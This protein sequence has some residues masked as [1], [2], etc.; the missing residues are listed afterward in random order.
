MIVFSPQVSSI[1]TAVLLT[2][3]H[4][5]IAMPKGE[6]IGPN[7]F[8]SLPILDADSYSL[9]DIVTEYS[10]TFTTQLGWLNEGTGQQLKKMIQYN[11][12][13]RPIDYDVIVAAID[14]VLEFGPQYCLQSL[15][16]TARRFLAKAR[17]VQHEVHRMIGFIRF[18]PVDDYTLVNKP[19]L[20]HNTADLILRQ[21]QPRYPEYKLV[22]ILDTYALSIHK[23]ILAKEPIEPYHSYLQTDEV[24][25]L[26][27]RYYLS[28]NISSRENIPLAQQR[29]PQ[30][31]WDW[32]QEGKILKEHKDMKHTKKKK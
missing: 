25:E 2:K 22:L 24:D 16:A 19:K 28:Q 32:M 5:D 6:E 14:E 11:L 10:S 1:F 29:I 7:L 21:F 27:S 26:W 20:F 8:S 17:A 31:Y 30:K 3:L 15:S 13:H 18:T 23:H 4:N 9:S 12:R